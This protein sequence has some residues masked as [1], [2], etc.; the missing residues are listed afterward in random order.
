MAI[1]N[2]D[3]EN[4]KAY[5]PILG[6]ERDAFPG[7]IIPEEQQTTLNRLMAQGEAEFRALYDAVAATGQLS[8][9]ELNGILKAGKIRA[10]QKREEYLRA[11][12]SNPANIIGTVIQSLPP[13][14]PSQIKQASK[15]LNANVARVVELVNIAKNRNQVAG[16]IVFDTETYA[17]GTVASER[18]RV[19]TMLGTGQ[20]AEQV[21]ENQII[22]LLR[23]LDAFPTEE[24]QSIERLLSIIPVASNGIEFRTEYDVYYREDVTSLNR[25]RFTRLALPAKKPGLEGIQVLVNTQI[26]RPGEYTII[27]SAIL[28]NPRAWAR[29][30]DIGGFSPLPEE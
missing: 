13:L 12:R 4:L 16:N 6:K 29:I 18:S 3:Q 19:L 17:A 11:I 28:A 25:E 21:K 7:E 15:T 22:E 24:P 27:G 26:L 1:D 10:E 30:V 23:K 14:F 20:A 2:G 9:P 5:D 8:E